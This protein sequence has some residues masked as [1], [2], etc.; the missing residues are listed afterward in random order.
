MAGNDIN[1]IKET[2]LSPYMMQ[3]CNMVKAGFGTLTDIQALDT[4]EF[5]DILEYECISNDIQK[6]L[7]DK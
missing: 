5:L 1:Y 4:P 7:M 6:Y 3:C 2:N